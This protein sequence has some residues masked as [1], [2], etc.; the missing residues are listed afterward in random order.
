MPTLLTFGS[1]SEALQVRDTLRQIVGRSRDRSD[2]EEPADLVGEVQFRIGKTDAT[3]NKGTTPG[4]VSIWDGSTVAGLADT[5]VNES[6]VTLFGTVASGKWVL[7][8]GFRFGWL[9]LAA[10]C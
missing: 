8:I 5:L 3:I 6:A 4:T 7:L 1:A 2:L 10:E 9:I